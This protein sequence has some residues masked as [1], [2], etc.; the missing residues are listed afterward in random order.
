MKQKLY[1]AVALCV[2]YTENFV[3]PRNA[4][5]IPFSWRQG[6]MSLIVFGALL[7]PI[8]LATATDL[9]TPVVSHVELGQTSSSNQIGLR[10]SPRSGHWQ[11]STISF[12]CGCP[13][14]CGERSDLGLTAS[15]ATPTE[16]ITIA[17]SR[18]IPFGTWLYLDGMGWRRVED[19]LAPQ[20]ED[21]IDVFLDGNDAH[22]R[23]KQ[24]GLREIWVWVPES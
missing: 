17:A 12:Y 7:P 14:C 16:G 19:R 10:Q 9:A 11:K 24:L 20:F 8:E 23:A 5:S 15:G 1:A 4:R 13:R 3:F 22:Q 2:A 18:G 6:L 21:R